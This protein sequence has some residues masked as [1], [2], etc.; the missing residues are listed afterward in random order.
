MNFD[1][2][3]ISL[4]YLYKNNKKLIYVI[5]FSYLFHVKKKK[6]TI[7]KNIVNFDKE[8]KKNYEMKSHFNSSN[9]CFIF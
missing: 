7:F 4:L 2:Q 1:N 5:P 3:R 9:K 8:Y 6:F